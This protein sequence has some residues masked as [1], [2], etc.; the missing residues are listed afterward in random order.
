MFDRAGVLNDFFRFSTTDLKW[1]QLGAAARVSG[2]PPSRRYSHGMV[3]VGSDLYVFGGTGNTGEEGLCDDGHRLGACQIERLGDAP[4]AA[5]V[6]PGSG[7][8]R[9][10]I[11]AILAPWVPA[12][13]L[14]NIYI[15]RG[16]WCTGGPCRG[17]YRH[18]T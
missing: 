1:E 8:A 10:H 15:S 11:T 14:V 6:A 4:R 2:S 12:G 18:V 5:A 13:A 17:W 3:S 16:R 9:R 7:D